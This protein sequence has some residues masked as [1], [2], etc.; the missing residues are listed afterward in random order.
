MENPLFTLS[1]VP[2]LD[3]VKP[4]HYMPAVDKAIAEI[5]RDVKRIKENKGAAT[6]ENT[7]VPLERLFKGLD[8]I[9]SILS[10]QS[11][12]TY[13]EELGKVEGAINVKVAGFRKSVFQDQALGARFQDVYAGRDKLKLDEDDKAIMR[14]LYH[15]F[16]ES[17]ALL[18]APDQ[19][20]IRE[21]DETLIGLSKKFMDNARAASLMEAV[22]ITDKAE[23]AGLTPNEIKRMESNARE[24]GHA[25]GWLF[26]PERLLVDEMLEHAESSS[27]RKKIHESVNRIGTHKDTDNN[28]VLAEIQK[29]RHEYA[30][31][32]GYENYASF[33]RS[34]AMNKDLQ[35]VRGLLQEVID[36]A[37][38]KFERD[39]KE[40]EKFSQA[41]GGPAKLEP[42]DV[43]FWA[44]KQR[45]ALFNFDAN[46][47][48]KHLQVDNVIKS[49]FSE[50]GKLFHIGFRENTGKYPVMHPDTRTYEVVNTDTGKEVGVL[51]LDLYA[52]PGTKIG[53]AWMSQIQSKDDDKKN[54]VIFN[55]NLTKPDDGSQAQVAL[56]Q[57]ITMY[58][59]MGHALQ[60]LLGTNVKYHSL[61]G[62]AA[63]ADFVEFHSM[64]N[65]HRAT[66]RENLRE[67]ALHAETGLPPSDAVIDA[68]L[69]SSSHFGTKEL[70]KMVQNSL[71]DL[72]FHMMDPV[73][74]K[75]VAELQKSVA[76]KSEYAEHVRPYALT[77]FDHLFSDAHSSYAAGYVN[78]LIANVLASDGFGPFKKNPD[79]PAWSKRL[80]ELYERG[81]GGE[82]AELYR[83]YLGRDAKP[84]AMLEEAGIESAAADKKA[85]KRAACGP[86]R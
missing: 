2:A 51:H 15:A 34:R 78:Y 24:N 6:F 10:N 52:R 86:K 58:H 84:D 82:P 53:G 46:D 65:E 5:E 45:H 57:Y 19:K 74:Y 32:L 76:M 56:T 23:L 83:H 41:N 68:L 61:Q 29:L 37:L 71:R 36:K 18:S 77:R 69:K 80:K 26:I 8:Y 42:W 27:F 48:S 54:V 63:P 33:A 60:G 22:L 40:L 50:A 21:I 12:N 66:L 31:L 70:L 30:E 25:K 20:R 3:A 67:F 49:L 14:D 1:D 44:E 72:E 59:E 75:G 7:V 4:E 55:M 81:S 13:S 11:C 62:T 35:A 38:P 85:V 73:Q 9:Q 17:G 39:M 64:V 43:S 47:F 79:D 16:E 28:P